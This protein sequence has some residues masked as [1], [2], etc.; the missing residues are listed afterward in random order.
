MPYAVKDREPI[1]Y[2]RDVFIACDILAVGIADQEINRFVP[3]PLMQQID[4]GLRAVFNIGIRNAF[5][6]NGPDALFEPFSG[7]TADNV[8]RF[9]IQ[10]HEEFCERDQIIR[11]A[12]KCNLFA[13]E[14]LFHIG[15]Q[16]DQASSFVRDRFRYFYPCCLAQCHQEAVG[17]P[18]S[19]GNVFRP[20]RHLA[21]L[22]ERNRA[23]LRGETAQ[24][25][26]ILAVAG[27]FQCRY[28]DTAFRVKHML[29]GLRS[30]EHIRCVGKELDRHTKLF[31]EPLDFPHVGRLHPSGHDV[32]LIELFSCRF[33]KL[34]GHGCDH[35]GVAGDVRADKAWCRG[36]DHVFSFRNLAVNLCLG[37]NL[38]Q[39]VPDRF[40]KT[41]RVDGNQVRLVDS[42]DIVD[43]RYKVC[44]AS[45]YRGAFRERACCSHDRLFVMAC[46]GAAMV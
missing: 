8:H 29:A 31:G 1:A 20:E 34:L 44:L 32:D 2:K 22:V 38:L 36:I 17:C 26:A 27:A 35:V 37:D 45:E 4:V 42:K 16:I 7:G 46:Q 18:E 43:C 14:V 19:Y 5:S 24:C 30:I 10:V 15:H 9:H 6:Q 11:V 28:R 33:G 21:F 13:V 3:D 25:D 39:V 23:R 12:E 41:G 40:R